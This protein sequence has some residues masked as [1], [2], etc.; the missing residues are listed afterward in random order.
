MKKLSLCMIVKN[1]EKVL[2]RCLDSAKQ[3]VDEIIIVDTGST[4][5]TLDIAKRY[6]N[7]VYS[8]EWTQDFA[9]ARNFAISKATCEFVMWLDAD[10][11]ITKDNLQ[12]LLILKQN[13]IFD[14]YMLKYQIGFDE[15]GNC[16]FEYYRE[17]IFRRCDKANFKGF[18][19]EA[20]VPFGKISYEDIAITH[21]SIKTEKSKNRNLKIYQYHLKNGAKLSARETFYYARELYFNSYYKKTI[22][23]LKKYLKMNNKF[24][25][26][27]IDAHILISDCYLKLND[28]NLAKKWLFDSFLYSTPNA[29]INCKLGNIFVLQKDYKS[30]I[31]YYMSALI[32][33][34]DIE[35]GAF[36]ENDYYDFLPF[37]Q[38]SFC[39]YNIGDYNNFEKYHNLAKAIKPTDKS[40]LHNEQF[41]KH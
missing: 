33:Q 36:I 41:I 14:T 23:V 22:E 18:I 16:T 28:V 31:Y 7:K 2:A 15:N 20:V 3:F 1:E 35:S 32:C 6:T 27:I 11:V 21:K 37:L 40:I 17:R 12:K 10:D 4:D 26:N 25:P 30:A 38:L 29:I 8:F 13:L 34:K 19:H 39:Y 9:K 24:L 5:K